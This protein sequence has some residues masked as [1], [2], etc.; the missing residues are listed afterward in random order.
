MQPNK[1][2]LALKIGA[3]VLGTSCALTATADTFTVAVNTISDVTITPVNTGLDFGEN[4]VTTAS[5]TC[6]MDA[7]VPAAAD[8]NAVN[9]ALDGTGFGDLTGGGCVTG[10]SGTPGIWSIDGVAGLAVNVSVADVAQ[11]GGDFTYTPI[12]C[13]V[14]YDGGV[15]GDLCST[16][17]VAG[18]TVATTV[19]DNTA[20]TDV[21]INAKTYFAVGGTISTGPTGLTS[22]TTYTASFDVTVTY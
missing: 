7:A 8:V 12:G 18:G 17:S 5:Q 13:V 21:P 22:D 15:A 20:D 2:K 16:L 4:I 1:N 14:V 11:V 9:A 6:T 10:S 19:A 3:L